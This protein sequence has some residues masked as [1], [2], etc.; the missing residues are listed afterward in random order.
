MSIILV[1]SLEK[2]MLAMMAACGF[3]ESEQGEILRKAGIVK[4]IHLL[5][6]SVRDMKASLI[7]CGMGNGDAGLMV[8]MAHWYSQWF[9]ERE[10]RD[11]FGIYF[12]EENFEKF[13]MAWDPSVVD[14]A[15]LA[16][17]SEM[18]IESPISEMGVVTPVSAT[19]IVSSDIVTDVKFEEA[20]DSR[21]N[22]AM[23]APNNTLASESSV[24]SAV[25]AVVSEVKG[26]TWDPTVDFAVVTPCDTSLEVDDA[27]SIVTPIMIDN[28]VLKTDVRLTSDLQLPCS[29]DISSVKI[30]CVKVSVVLTDDW[31]SPRDANEPEDEIKKSKNKSL[32]DTQVVMRLR[33]LKMQLKMQGKRGAH[34]FKFGLEIPQFVKYKVITYSVV[35]VNVEAVNVRA[36]VLT[37]TLGPQV[38]HWLLAKVS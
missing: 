33:C 35:A 21:V 20:W 16:P 23:Q 10:L 4:P 17:I 18:G 36:D 6:I 37:K 2:E 38:F 31:Y 14:S 5:C 8:A 15:M 25:D 22:F 19:G 1:P 9:E 34:E 28:D 24:V 7:A 13:M 11:V 30:D 27:V 26:E 3:E 32:D 29:A 12:T